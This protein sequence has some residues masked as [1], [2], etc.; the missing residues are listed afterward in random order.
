MLSIICEG[1]CPILTSRDGGVMV[2][3]AIQQ[4][5]LLT[6]AGGGGRKAGW[7]RGAMCSWSRFVVRRRVR[8]H[9]TDICTTRE[10]GI[11]K[12][13]RLLPLPDARQD[14]RGMR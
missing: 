11:L 6:A 12:I 9:N 13:H 5:G 3:A 7:E 4:G 8:Y 10:Y 1:F 14:R 2:V